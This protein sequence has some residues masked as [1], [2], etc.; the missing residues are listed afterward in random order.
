MGRIVV[1]QF[2]TVDGV[3]EDPGGSESFDRG[4]WAFEFDRGPEG[5]K[6]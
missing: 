1:S 4:G 3:I 2:V 5:D 6:F